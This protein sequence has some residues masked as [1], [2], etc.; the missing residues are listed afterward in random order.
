MPVAG[1]LP[2]RAR[3]LA[4]LAWP[5]ASAA[6]ADRDRLDLTGRQNLTLG[7][8]A[9]AMGMGGAFLARADDATAAS[10]NPA[11][12]SYLRVPEVSLV[13]V[14]NK[15]AV[16]RPMGSG[17]DILS[18]SDD[19]E[20]QSRRFRRPDLAARD[21]EA[22]GGRPAQ[23]PAGDLVRRD[24]AG[25]RSSSP[26]KYTVTRTDD[27]SSDG[28]FDVIA[29]GTGFRLTRSLRAGITVNRWLNGYT[30]SFTRKVFD[31][32]DTKRPKRELDFRFRPSGWNFNVGLMWSPI[33]PLNVAAV[34][35]TPFT[36]SVRLDQSRRDYLGRRA[37]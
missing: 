15:F 3:V 11:G 37:R 20:G 22:A 33:E 8:G 13:G 2:S 35:K 25:S 31:P 34:Y 19:F 12:L 6:Q 7:S 9:R 18:L 4:L 26:G 10:W 30:Q 23:L 14:W 5:V 27:F 17:S 24:A 1:G 16:E 32:P 29:L 21:Q 36:A 28:G